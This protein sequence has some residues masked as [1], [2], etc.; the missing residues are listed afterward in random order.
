LS[1]LYQVFPDEI[2]GSGQFGIVYG[3][4][5]ELSLNSKSN[6]KLGMIHISSSPKLFQFLGVHRET[7]KEV[8]VKIVDKLRFPTKQATQLKNE[9]SILQV[10]QS[11]MSEGRGYAGFSHEPID[12]SYLGMK[13]FLFLQD[14]HHQGVVNLYHFFE[15]P[16]KVNSTNF[17]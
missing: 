1:Q 9:V 5:K 15:T 12:S 2:L 4:R 7:G 10:M 6:S 11:S 8:A 17:V 13:F 14:L 3:G 16:E